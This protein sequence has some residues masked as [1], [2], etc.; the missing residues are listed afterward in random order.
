MIAEIFGKISSGSNLHDRLEDNLAG[1]V[2]GMTLAYNPILDQRYGREYCRTNIDV[3]FGTYKY[4]PDEKIKFAGC[5]PL[6]A[7][8]TKSLKNAEWKTA[9]SGA[10]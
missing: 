5:V 1:N 6:K 7:H 8:G 2:F 3:S 9:L 10:L 4:A